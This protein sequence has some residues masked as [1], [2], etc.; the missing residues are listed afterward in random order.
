MESF[1]A[2]RLFIFHK[3][4]KIWNPIRIFKGY[5]FA[6]K[7]M[8]RKEMNVL[9]ASL[10][11]G[12]LASSCQTDQNKNAVDA[13]STLRQQ[14]DSIVSPHR[15]VVGV[16]ILGPNP[17]DTLS[18]HGDARFPLQSVFKYHAAIPL[19]AQIDQGTYSLDHTITLT[20]EDLNTQL[21]SPM[22]TAHS[23]GEEVSMATLMRYSIAESDNVACDLLLLTL[24]GPGIVQD[25]FHGKGIKDLA[26]QH[27]EVDMQAQWANM[28][29]NWTTPKAASQALQHFLI[30]QDQ[31]LSKESHQF[32][33]NTMRA[34]QTGA[35]RLKAL[36]PPGTVIAHKTG[37]SGTNEEGFTPATNDIGVIYLPDG[38]Y[39]IIS[40]LVGSSYEDDTTNARIIAEIAKAAYHHFLQS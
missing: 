2:M 33:W 3:S 31:S 6:I 20:Q 38:R 11:I 26:I 30:N 7:H 13:L 18:F 9:L 37:S 8:I 22:S 17:S 1:P 5:R 24:G 29:D 27:N 34:T 21:Y 16:S 19:L 40:V 15:A 23:V 32:L 14:I 25:Y 39:F 4:L 10:F 36:L 35:D 12:C 28:Y